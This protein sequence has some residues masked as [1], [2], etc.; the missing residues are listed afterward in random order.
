MEIRKE[1]PE[2]LGRKAVNEKDTRTRT[3]L[4]KIHVRE[5]EIRRAKPVMG[6]ITSTD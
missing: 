5:T 4:S 1:N 3:V 2:F 6:I